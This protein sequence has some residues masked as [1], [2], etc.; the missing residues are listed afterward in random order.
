[1]SNPV[2]EEHVGLIIRIESYFELDDY[3]PRMMVD[4]IDGEKRLYLKGSATDFE[5]L[6]SFI[7]EQ[8]EKAN[9]MKYIP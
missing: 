1:M 3:T 4:I 5:A 2:F 6:V 7:S 8:V 9:E